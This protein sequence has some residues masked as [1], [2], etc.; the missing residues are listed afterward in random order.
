MKFFVFGF[1]RWPLALHKKLDQV[2]PGLHC[3]VS[4]ESGIQA[5]YEN[6]AFSNVA[7]CKYLSFKEYKLVLKFQRYWGIRPEDSA[8]YRDW[9]GIFPLTTPVAFGRKRDTCMYPKE[10]SRGGLAVGSLGNFF[11]SSSL[12]CP[13]CVPVHCF[14][15]TTNMEN[16]FLGEKN[17]HKMFLLTIVMFI[18]IN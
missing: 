10:T 6:Y 16:Y 8:Y 4:A 7:F 3:N 18:D 14:L 17:K 11:M 9:C 13:A 5:F 2:K 15:R 12:F 1:W